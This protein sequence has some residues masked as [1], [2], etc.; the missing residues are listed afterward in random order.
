MSSIQLQISIGQ[1]VSNTQSCISTRQQVSRSDGLYLC[2]SAHSVYKCHGS[3][4]IG[5]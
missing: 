1:L 5:L 4:V 2:V 3:N